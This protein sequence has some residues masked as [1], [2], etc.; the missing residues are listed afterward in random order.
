M[1][2]QQ[3]QSAANT[4]AERWPTA[5]LKRNGVGNLCVITDGDRPLAYVDLFDGEV[6]EYS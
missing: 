6:V 3:L 1:T 5:D 2:P 4:I